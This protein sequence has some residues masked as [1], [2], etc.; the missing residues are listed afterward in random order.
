MSF[1]SMLYLAAILVVCKYFVQAPTYFAI[2]TSR[3]YAILPPIL[4]PKMPIQ[5][6][7]TFMEPCTIL[8]EK[9]LGFTIAN[10]SLIISQSSIVFHSHRLLRLMTWK[11]RRKDQ[12]TRK[13]PPYA[14][15]IL[16]VVFSA[17]FMRIFEILPHPGLEEFRVIMGSKRGGRESD[18]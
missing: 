15:L 6:T 3:L 1:I 4:L 12:W 17:D 5:Q 16:N 11:A 8:P 2:K 10:H 9:M 13:S 7:L 18:K 14:H